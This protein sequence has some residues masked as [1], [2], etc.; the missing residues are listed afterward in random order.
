MI[1]GT[2]VK[3]EGPGVSWIGKF[4]GRY[5]ETGHPTPVWVVTLTEANTWP[6]SLPYSVARVEK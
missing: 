5:L 4:Q 2:L 3:T 1:Q 6:D